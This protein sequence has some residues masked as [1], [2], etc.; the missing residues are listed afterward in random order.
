MRASKTAHAFPGSLERVQLVVSFT[1]VVNLALITQPSTDGSE[2]R[3]CR[4]VS[5]DIGV[6]QQSMA[7]SDN[8]YG[9]EQYV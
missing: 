5:E 4:N 9:D 6:L 2:V 8:V 7:W 1:M 3:A